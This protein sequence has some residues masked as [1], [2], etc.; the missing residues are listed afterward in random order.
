MFNCMFCEEIHL[1]MTR[2]T[3]S[4]STPWGNPKKL[5]GTIML[6]LKNITLQNNWWV[7]QRPF[8]EQHSLE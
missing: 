7:V 2:V 1:Q 6:A 3:Y 4:K 8:N 5:S